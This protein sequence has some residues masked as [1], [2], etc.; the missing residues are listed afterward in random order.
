MAVGAA[1]TTSS[2]RE[3]PPF[4][5]PQRTHATAP[6]STHSTPATTVAT[7][8]T[9]NQHGTTLG[10]GDA[11]GA[12]C[13]PCPQPQQ[14]CSC[15]ALQTHTNTLEIAATGGQ[16]GKQEDKGRPV[17]GA[18]EQAASHAEQRQCGSAPPLPRPQKPPAVFSNPI[19]RQKE[20]P[21]CSRSVSLKPRGSRNHPAGVNRSTNA[22]VKQRFTSSAWKTLLHGLER[23]RVTLQR[24]EN[25][26][27]HSR[28]WEVC[29]HHSHHAALHSQPLLS[30]LTLPLVTAPT[31]D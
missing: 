1:P 16:A 20:Q 14:C 8:S 10:Q 3:V 4:T 13:T 15:L 19:C 22:G 25:A 29:S 5:P 30:P 6:G 26:C 17:E 9:H 24:L 21:M 12:P 2:H 31:T 18:A 11:E 27:P 7:T 28:G 23:Y